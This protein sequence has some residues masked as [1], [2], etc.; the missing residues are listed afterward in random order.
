MKALKSERAKKLTPAE[1]T[2][3]LYRFNGYMDMQPD[4][5][6]VAYEAA[7]M[8]EEQQKRIEQ[9]EKVCKDLAKANEAIADLIFNR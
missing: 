3:Y 7:I 9:L 6:E 8:I 2:K 4:L 1:L 5:L